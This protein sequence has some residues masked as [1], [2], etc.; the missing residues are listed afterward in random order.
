MN[1]NGL[2][3]LRK[4][5]IEKSSE[6]LAESFYDYP[7]YR[8]I[9]GQQNNI[10]K[11]K[12]FHKYLIKYGVLYGEAYA[13]SKELEGIILFSQFDDYKMSFVRTLRSGAL[14]LIRLGKEAGMRFAEYDKFSSRIHR[15]SL[16]EPH[17]YIISVGVNPDKQGQGFA[18]KL[19]RAVLSYAQEMGQPCY[20]ETHSENNVQIYKRYGFQVISEDIVPGTDITQ[21]SMI[22]YHS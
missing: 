5:D 15:E 1:I 3:K 22:K 9:L 16:Q 4:S 11:I 8:H 19:M 17:I 13:S 18:S 2:Y 6:I 7:I 10:Q 21:Y 20:L 14:S 12:V